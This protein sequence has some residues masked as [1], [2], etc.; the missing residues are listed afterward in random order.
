MQC[1]IYKPNPSLPNQE[2][3]QNTYTIHKTGDFSS[4]FEEKRPLNGSEKRPPNDISPSRE[5]IRSP[6]RENREKRLFPS[7]PLYFMPALLKNN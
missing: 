7:I 6:E 1:S 2:N 4:N 5:L 3:L